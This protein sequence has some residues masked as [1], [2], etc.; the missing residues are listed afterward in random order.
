[1]NLREMYYLVAVA[2][3]RNFSKAAEYCNVSQPTLSAQIKK[4]EGSLDI[5]IFERNNK[6]VLLTDAGETIIKSAKNIINEVDFIKEFVK[7]SHDPLSG[8][9]TLGA[10]PTLATYIFPSVVSKIKND[11]PN[12]R[13]VL[14]E[15]KTAI[16]IDKLKNGKIDAALL[17]LPIQE[18]F[19]VSQKL[20]DDEFY[21]AVPTGHTLAKN[22]EISQDMLKNYP[23]LLLEEGHC[24]RDQ[25]LE[26]CQ[27]HNVGEEQDVKATGMET[28]RQMVKAGTG[29]TFIPKIAQQKN[30][31]GICY[32]PFEKP[33]PTRTIGLVWRKT[34]QKQ[35]V[36][37]KVMKY[38][39]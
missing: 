4:L 22:K 34:F 21:L 15:E 39:T 26:V 6:H 17:A 30:E 20:F 32:V 31:Q 38:F 23:L 27:M 8:K 5:K 12:L 2:N 11:M 14:V 35:Q 25:A 10:F 19:L 13:L 33:A 28:L 9:L 29:I 18:D 24:L 7:N 1:M 3:L 36:L 37:D 16:L